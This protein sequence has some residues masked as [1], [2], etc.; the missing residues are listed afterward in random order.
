MSNRVECDRIKEKVAQIRCLYQET[1]LTIVSSYG[2]VNRM[3]DRFKIGSGRNMTDCRKKIGLVSLASFLF[4][5]GCLGSEAAQEKTRPIEKQSYQEQPFAKINYLKQMKSSP[6]SKQIDE[7]DLP[8][9]KWVSKLTA[10]EQQE[11]AKL[12]KKILFYHG[13]SFK[14]QVALTFDDGPDK[15]FTIQVLDILKKEQVPATFF[16][17]GYRSKNHP[18]VL[19]RIDQ[20]GHIIGNHSYNHPQFTKISLS[21]VDKQISQTN[22]YI[23]QAIQKTPLLVRPPYGSIN[24]KV[25]KHLGKKGYKVIQWSVDTVDWKGPTSQQIV[26]TVKR[27]TKPGG[28]ILQHSAGGEQLQQSVDALP[29]IIRYFKSQGYEFVTVDQLLNVPAYA[30]EV[31]K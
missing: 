10:K 18:D 13:P 20:E 17:V 26:H 28:I 8:N 14:K 21:Q 22:H 16:V 4:V 7:E 5:S 25:T 23:H 24:D 30:E 11:V 29:E 27:D 2:K 31:K 6:A 15:N 1:A 3:N 9:K 19:K 12:K